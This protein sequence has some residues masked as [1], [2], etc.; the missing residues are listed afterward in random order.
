MKKRI[1]SLPL[2]VLLLV[3]FGI[4]SAMAQTD[5]GAVWDPY[6][7]YPE[8]ISFTKGVTKVTSGFPEGQDWENNV[9][10]EFVKE[11]INVETKVAWEVDPANLDQKIALS[12]A[13]GDIPDMMIVNRKVFQQLVENDLIWDMTEAYE[14]C[15]SP[16]LRQQFD[17]FG[18]ALMNEVMVNGRMMGIP[19]T[20][21]GYCHNVLWIRKDWMEN[22]GMEA[23]QTLDE[24]IAMAK[25]FIEQDPDGNGEADTL[26][27]TANELLF[28][29]YN[30]RFG[31]D[32]VAA[33][34]GAYPGAWVMHEGQ[35]AYGTTLPGMQ[36]ALAFIRGLYQQGILDKEFAVRKGEDRDA[37]L[38]SGKLGMHFGVWWPAGG[39]T[40]S[41]QNNPD[42]DWIC[43]SAPINA[44]GKLT[45]PVNDPLASI[46]V[47]SKKYA[48]PEAI[49]KALNV[50]YDSLRGN[51]EAGEAH[52]QY[53]N[54]NFGGIGWGAMP[55]GIA[56]D[57]ND[58]IGKLLED[59]NAA[60]AA[61]DVSVMKSKGFNHTF[62]AIKKNL[63][64]PRQDD[65]AYMEY[66][67]RIVGTTAAMD[68]NVEFV[69]SAFFGQT[70][71][72][73]TKWAHLQ[74]LEQETLIQI[75]MGEKPVEDFD[76]FVDQ[77]L[78]LGG[79]DILD[80]I[81]AVRAVR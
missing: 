71:S 14:Q 57:Y 45:T 6:T 29:G 26:G 11:Q 31:L 61:D 15:I 32:T 17:S 44:D 77:W 8:T 79:Q 72:M 35:P 42:A 21:I 69:E 36:D 53:W 56:I 70:E 80:E 41:V 9:Y 30:G 13:N 4:L 67:A 2:A 63:E 64:N 40:A 78:K 62:E 74:K 23:P 50:G 5:N 60:L 27:L 3:S 24:V 34:F 65:V 47:V 37:L 52:Y 10:T 59:L 43:V 33:T 1:F 22:L 16:F 38:A 46:V 54:E 25:A 58:A 18:D 73:A 75:V 68:P 66:L 49:V 81:A 12:I 48:H 19:S 76:K 28:S 51:G 7:P 39:V 20:N 55:V